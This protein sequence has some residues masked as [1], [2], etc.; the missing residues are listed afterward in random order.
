MTVLALLAAE[1]I[2][3]IRTLHDQAALLAL[4]VLVTAT[5]T[6][7]ILV[8]EV[9]LFDLFLTILTHNSNLGHGLFGIRIILFGL[10]IHRQNKVNSI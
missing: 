6:D 2:G 5:E 8:V 10:E 4:D 9:N 7:P 1:V 3:V